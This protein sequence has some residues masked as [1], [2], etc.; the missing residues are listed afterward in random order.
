MEWLV[1]WRDGSPL[2]HIMTI[3]NDSIDSRRRLAAI[4][5]VRHVLS[6]D[7]Y[8]FSRHEPIDGIMHDGYGFADWLYAMYR[9]DRISD[10]IRIS[11]TKIC[12]NI[13]RIGPAYTTVRNALIERGVLGEF[14][15]TA[16]VASTSDDVRYFTMWA[17]ARFVDIRT[18]AVSVQLLTRIY[19]TAFTVFNN[20][21]T[22][23]LL[24]IACEV[25]TRLSYSSSYIHLPAIDVV[26][27]KYD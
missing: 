26:W 23:R 11:L 6:Y 25:F 18:S 19:S 16:R 5:I 14:I 4:E 20:T 13:L 22:P 15:T 8:Q 24:R 10:D 3:A 12:G 27:D 21:N 7:S 1:R 2:R 17:I 9:T